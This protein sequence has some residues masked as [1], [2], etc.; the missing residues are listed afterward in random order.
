MF[1]YVWVGGTWRGVNERFE[2]NIVTLSTVHVGRGY[3]IDIIL[4]KASV[5]RSV[6]RELSPLRDG[7][8]GGVVVRH[9]CQN[10]YR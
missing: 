8:G 10:T 9:A 4:T 3:T 7:A 2:I 1:V 6:A 5:A